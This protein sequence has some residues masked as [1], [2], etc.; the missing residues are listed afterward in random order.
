MNQLSDLDALKMAYLSDQSNPDINPNQN[1]SENSF[2][3]N[4]KIETK[5]SESNKNG[6]NNSKSILKER[7]KNCKICFISEMEIRQCVNDKEKNKEENNKI[8]RQP[9]GK[10]QED[11]VVSF[12][13]I[14]ENI[15]GR[16]PDY[17]FQQISTKNK[18]FLFQFL[19]KCLLN[20]D[21]KGLHSLL[22]IDE[23]NFAFCKDNQSKC[24]S[25]FSTLTKS[26]FRNSKSLSLMDFP[27]IGLIEGNDLNNPIC[28]NIQ[29][30]ESIWKKVR[31]QI[32]V[33]KTAE[34][35]WYKMKNTLKSI[36]NNLRKVY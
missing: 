2:T 22:D 35:K 29:K 25:D 7:N 9:F 4:Q 36:L 14:I 10:S 3:S 33:N 17:L 30:I 5:E 18:K 20:I 15:F 32:L 13:E 26:N 28:N 34:N 23:Y 16:L 31:E 27:E 8:R 12:E 24:T 1:L 6:I 11:F 21:N 19:L